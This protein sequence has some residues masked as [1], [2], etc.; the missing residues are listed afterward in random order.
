MIQF[1]CGCQLSTFRFVWSAPAANDQ[2]P[3]FVTNA[4]LRT[5]VRSAP[6]P[7]IRSP[8]GHQH[9][10][11]PKHAKIDQTPLSPDLTAVLENVDFSGLN[12]I[13]VQSVELASQINF[14]HGIEGV[15]NSILLGSTKSPTKF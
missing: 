11:Q 5:K 3:T 6:K 1:E 8:S 10:I 13:S 15:R 2:F 4:A 12:F 14:A 9:Q 7:V